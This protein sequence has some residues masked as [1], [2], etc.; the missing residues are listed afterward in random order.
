MYDDMCHLVRSAIKHMKKDPI[1]AEFVNK[2]VKVVDPFHHRTHV[3][4]FCRANCDPKAHSFLVQNQANMEI[5][6]QV[7]VMTRLSIH[8]F[9]SVDDLFFLFL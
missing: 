8:V 3:G 6:E 1:I 5:C 7:G 2:P 9:S 4:A